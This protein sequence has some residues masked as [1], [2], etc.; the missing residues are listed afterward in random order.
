MKVI[1]QDTSTGLFYHGKEEWAQD[2]ATAYNFRSS[3]EAIDY[4]QQ[5]Q[6]QDGEIILCFSEARY[7]IRLRAFAEP[8]Q[9]RASKK[10]ARKERRC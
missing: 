6:I 10:P 7:D 1:L 2:S 8:S 4:C 5:K 9:R 3:L